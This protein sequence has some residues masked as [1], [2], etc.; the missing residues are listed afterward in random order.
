ME[1]AVVIRDS[2]IEIDLIVFKVSPTIGQ[3]R[4][5]HS[6]VMLQS[7]VAS[8][9]SKVTAASPSNMSVRVCKTIIQVEKASVVM[10]VRVRALSNKCAMPFQ[11]HVS[12]TS[13]EIARWHSAS[14]D[15]DDAS[16]D[17]AYGASCGRCRYRNY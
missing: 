9:S 1:S 11:V 8:R 12:R 5:Q 14:G 2:V 7:N 15:D 17:C 4:L 13:V 10:T 6:P 3:F 16:H